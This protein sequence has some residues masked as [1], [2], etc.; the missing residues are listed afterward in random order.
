MFK[1]TDSRADPKLIKTS[2]S[3]STESFRLN[4]REMNV[5]AWIRTHTYT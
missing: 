3:L 1:T 2:N 5:C 4:L